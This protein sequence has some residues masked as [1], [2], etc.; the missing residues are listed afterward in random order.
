MRRDD[1]HSLGGPAGLFDTFTARRQGAVRRQLGEFFEVVA[2]PGE[3]LDDDLREGDLVIQRALGEGDLAWLTEIGISAPPAFEPGVRLP[4]DHLVL[5]PIELGEAAPSPAPDSPVANRFIA[6][7]HSRFC[8]PGQRGSQT[9]QGLVSPRPIRRVIIHVLAVPSTSRRSG[10]EAVVAG[11]QNADREASAH[12]LV[13]RDGT[14]TQMVREANVAFHTPGNNRDSIGIEHADVCNDP[15]PFT[16]QLYERSA[17]LVRNIAARKGFVIGPTTVLGHHDANPNHEDPGPYWDWEYYRL[18]LDWDGQNPLSRPVR[19]VTAA[20]GAPNAPTGWQTGQRRA[21]TN[22]HCASPRDPWGDRYWKARPA[23][24]AAAAE[25]TLMADEPGTYSVSLWWPNVVGANPAV[26]VEIATDCISSPCRQT[27]STQAATVDQRRNFGRW[28]FVATVTIDGPP[29]EVKVRLRRDSA[30]PGWILCDGARLLRIATRAPLPSVCSSLFDSA[31]ELEDT[32][33]IDPG[34]LD[35]MELID[36]HIDV[37]AQRSLRRL[38]LADAASSR[39]AHGMLRAVKSRELAGIY[40]A[41]QQ[42]PAL[43]AQRLGR[44]WWQLIPEGEDAVMVLEQGEPVSPPPVGDRGP[45]IAFR[46]TI[47]AQHE[48]L[49]RALRRAWESFRS[50][51]CG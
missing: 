11:W 24:S 5:R 25:L 41:D 1:L 30:Q 40:A 46:E 37:D 14:I 39:D 33:S 18:L 35:P 51:R 34:P 47:R 23:A 48:R 16:T 26:T 4:F 8:T 19:V 38:S 15:A 7:H 2:L 12:Y 13:D 31:G 6:A 44:G 43:R 17:A 27:S 50:L 22:D 32:G 9:C 28:N 10:V 42:V 3:R 20:A 36:P 21:I 29:A 45:L 49:D